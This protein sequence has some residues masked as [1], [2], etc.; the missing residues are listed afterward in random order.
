MSAFLPSPRASLV[1]PGCSLWVR[2][3]NIFH[4]LCPGHLQL[5][6]GY[7]VGLK[8]GTLKCLRFRHICRQDVRPG[9][10]VWG[11]QGRRRRVSIW[12]P[13]VMWQ[14]TT[15]LNSFPGLPGRSEQLLVVQSLNS[16]SHREKRTRFLSSAKC[17]R[18]RVFVYRHRVYGKRRIMGLN[19][20]R[21]FPNMCFLCCQ[22][23]VFAINK[24]KLLQH[25]NSK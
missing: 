2:G 8:G 1:Q 20:K 22:G 13:N 7:A 16:T 21:E 18:H 17:G 9:L 25:S 11:I 10:G 6:S 14:W 5:A 3:F 12:A 4:A 15:S 23:G 19:Q 24:C